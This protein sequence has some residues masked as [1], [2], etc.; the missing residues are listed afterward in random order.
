MMV[1]LYPPGF[2]M[3]VLLVFVLY[4]CCWLLGVVVRAEICSGHCV[5]LLGEISAV[6]STPKTFL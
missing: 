1:S 4:F 5:G 2:L 3:P 6:P